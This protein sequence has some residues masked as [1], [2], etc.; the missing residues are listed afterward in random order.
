[1]KA[2]VFRATRDVV[3]EDVEDARIERD[4]DAVVRVTSSA[5][6]GTDLHMYEGRTGATP[7]MVLG[8]EGLG[9]VDPQIVSR[10][11]FIRPAVC[12]DP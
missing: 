6:C 12:N 1:M 3:V 9:T 8:H 4:D 7:G 11:C 2:V 5:L 10:G